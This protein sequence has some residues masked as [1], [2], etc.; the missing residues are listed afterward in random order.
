M[1]GAT[2]FSIYLPPPAEKQIC[3]RRQAKP[4]PDPDIASSPALSGRAARENCRF[5]LLAGW[6]RWLRI[7][8]AVLSLVIFVDAAI[9]ASPNVVVTIKPVHS[10]AAAILE[11]VTKPKLLLD[12]AVSPH[13][14]ALKPSDA[15]ALSRADAVIRVS[16]NLENFLERAIEALPANARVIDLDRTPGLTLLPV[17]DGGHFIRDVKENDEDGEGHHHGR[18]GADVHFWLDPANAIAIAGNLAVAF[19]DMDPAHAAQY[20][21]NAETLKSKL[22]SLDAELKARLAGLSDRP[23]IVFHD[24]TQYFEKRYNL[25]SLGAITLSP[26]RAPGAR[27][28]A[29]IR[30]KI[31]ETQAICVFSE[32]QFPP[33][34]AQMLTEGTEAKQGV[35][36]EVGAAIPAGPDQYFHLLRADADSLAACLKS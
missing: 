14:Y 5:I 8:L 25:N 21:A 18:E 26:E 34:L 2:V 33:K 32:P 4:W 3:A 1:S 6:Q 23:F 31:K 15:E 24:V 10:L 28:L 30:A 9:C 20:R 36:D 17:R 22:R 11:G 35:L 19:S 7:T 27:R 12:G 29:A 16:A 13:S